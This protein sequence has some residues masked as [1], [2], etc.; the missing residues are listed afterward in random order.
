DRVLLARQPKWPASMYSILAGF[1]EPGESTEE[2]VVREV[3]EEVGLAVSEVAYVR[4]QPWPFPCSLMI[5][6]AMRSDEGEI[7][8]G[9]DELE[10][11]RWVSREEIHARDGLFVPPPFSLAGQ[12]IELF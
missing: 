11:A 6:Y 7:V 9:D 4:S 3:Q 1:V 10:D 2:A 12:L 8:L 5:G